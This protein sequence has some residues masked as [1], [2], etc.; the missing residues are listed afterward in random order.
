MRTHPV[1]RPRKKLTREEKAAVDRR[2]RALGRHIGRLGKAR[3]GSKGHPAHLRA[4]GQYWKQCREEAGLSAAAVAL[5]MG[6]AADELSL[7]ENGLLDLADLPEEY[8]DR[9]AG[10][11]GAASALET[12]Y[13]LFT[14]RKSRRM[15]KP[16]GE[17]SS[18]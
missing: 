2:V 17:G 12:Y 3:P 16:R 11:I 13:D 7:F 4:I 6:L 8:L 15:S 5:K 9:L 1:T 14:G 10:A 18:N